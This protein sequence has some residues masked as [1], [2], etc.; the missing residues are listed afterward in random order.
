MHNT[1]TH[2]PVSSIIIYIYVYVHHVYDD[3]VFYLFLQ[4]QKITYVCVRK[5]V[6]YVY[7]YIG[8]KFRMTKCRKFLCKHFVD[9]YPHRCLSLSHPYL[10]VICMHARISKC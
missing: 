9:T 8:E 4:K 2:T 3:D 10:H 1:N 6:I 5:G 7:M